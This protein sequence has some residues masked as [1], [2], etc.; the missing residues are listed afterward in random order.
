MNGDVVH[1]DLVTNEQGIIE[2]NDLRPGDYQ[3]IETKAPKH[4]VLDETPIKFTIEKGQKK[5]IS[6]TATN[7]LKQGSIELLKVDDLNTQT[8]LADAVFNLLDQDGKV[9][10]TDLKTNSEGKIVIENL[11]P[12]TYQFV[13][14][15]APEHYDLDKKPIIFTIEKS[16]KRYCYRYYEK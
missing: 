10:K 8:K 14:I 15:T 13:E 1:K 11:R 2:I 9:L 7:S 12:G 5:A 6:L 3:F 16:Q 4:Y